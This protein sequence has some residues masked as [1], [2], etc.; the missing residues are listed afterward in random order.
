MVAKR[1]RATTIT[2]RWDRPEIIGRE[3]LYYNIF[4]SE[5][6][7]TFIQH[8][9]RPYIKQDVVIDYS[10][11]GLKPLTLYFI[12]VTAE[13]GVSDQGVGSS[14]EVTGATG[15]ISKFSMYCLVVLVITIVRFTILSHRV[16]LCCHGTCQVQC[17]V[18]YPYTQC[19][20]HVRQT[21]N[22]YHF[23][24]HESVGQVCDEHVHYVVQ[25]AS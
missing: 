20:L 10:L 11:S 21:S 15:D 4:Y 16:W 25:L 3:G 19:S 8:N 12:R 7:Q 2:V 17:R 14:C 13:N 6:N 1:T 18:C 24:T 22:N 23:E 5:D 9:P